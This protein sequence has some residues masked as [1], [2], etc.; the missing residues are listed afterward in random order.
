MSHKEA[1]IFGWISI[2]SYLKN[3]LNCEIIKFTHLQSVCNVSPYWLVC[4]N[5]FTTQFESPNPLYQ[6]CIC[7]LRLCISTF[8]SRHTSILRYFGSLASVFAS[9]CQ[10]D[11]NWSLILLKPSCNSRHIFVAFAAGGVLLIGI[12]QEPLRVLLFQALGIEEKWPQQKMVKE[13]ITVP[14]HEISFILLIAVALLVFLANIKRA[15]CLKRKTV[16]F[17]VGELKYSFHFS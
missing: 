11:L 10:N 7:S 1:K 14:K 12:R 15:Q 17:V 2:L 6:S 3:R 4:W 8:I 5:S 9:S 16:V 13:A